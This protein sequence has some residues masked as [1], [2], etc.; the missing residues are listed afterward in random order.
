PSF[1]AVRSWRHEVSSRSLPHTSHRIRKG[2][3]SHGLV[4]LARQDAVRDAIQ[5]VEHV[6]QSVGVLSGFILHDV[7]TYSL[8][9]ALTGVGEADALPEF[10]ISFR[11]DFRTFE[12][13][14]I[15]GGHRDGGRFT[16]NCLSDTIAGW[17]QRRPQ[18]PIRP[19]R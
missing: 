16:P 15:S 4:D 14:W 19:L 11:Q 9:E 2:V 17:P 18:V 6:K 13:G 5:K 3:P 12:G 1:R 10:N 8:P 7:E